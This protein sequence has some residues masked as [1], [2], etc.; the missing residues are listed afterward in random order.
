MSAGEE[1]IIDCCDFCSTPTINT[2]ANASLIAAAPEMLDAL[3]VFLE[4]NDQGGPLSFNTDEMW[5]QARAA[6]AKAE[7]KV[8]P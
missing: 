8:M 4:Y 2:E 7:G 5:A 1:A 6:V 3:K